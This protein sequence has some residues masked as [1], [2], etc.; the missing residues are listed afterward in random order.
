MRHLPWAD[1]EID[2]HRV[3]R[4]IARYR[5]RPAA[6]LGRR[7]YV[8]SNETSPDHLVNLL[9]DGD[10]Q[11]CDCADNTLG[12]TVMCVHVIAALL[13]AGNPRVVRLVGDVMRDA[14]LDRPPPPPPMRF[15]MARP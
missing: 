13:H 14:W 10:E 8:V 15:G 2:A 12:G 5:A 6:D 9:A 3:L 11:L 1:A 4:V 7:V